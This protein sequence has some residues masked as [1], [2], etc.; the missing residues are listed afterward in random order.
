MSNHEA[1]AALIAGPTRLKRFETVLMDGR[2]N[3]DYT[4]KVNRIEHIPAYD[5]KGPGT[6]YVHL[7]GDTVIHPLASVIKVL[8]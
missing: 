3:P 2:A 7:V 1:L 5:G 6:Y 8:R 4:G